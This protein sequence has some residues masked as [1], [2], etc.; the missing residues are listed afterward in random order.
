[1]TIVG[2]A[3]SVYGDRD[4]LWVAARPYLDRDVVTAAS[5]VPG[6]SADPVSLDATII[7]A[8]DFSDPKKPRYVASSTIEGR[9][10]DQ[11]AMDEKAGSLRVVTTGQQV[12]HPAD[13]VPG[14]Q[15]KLTPRALSHLVVL[16]PDL[17]R[18]KVTGSA[19]DVAP[20]EALRTSRFIGDHAF[21]VTGRKVNPLV[22]IDIHDP[23]APSVVG[24]L[25]I[26]GF[27]EF[28]QPMDDTHLLT[29]GRDEKAGGTALSLSIF[30]IKNPNSP[31]VTQH[32]VYGGIDG[33]SA[34]ESDQKAFTYWADRGLLAFPYLGSTAGG[35]GG[36]K[37]TLEVFSVGASTGFKKLGSIDH[38]ALFAS[39]DG[40]CDRSYG[41]DVRRGTFIEDVVFS[42]SY[43]G[44]IA[45]S[46]SD[47]GTPLAKLQLPAPGG[48]SWVCKLARAR[49]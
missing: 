48:P 45:S 32:F 49:G 35:L 11:F 3:D 18:L 19:G 21:L 34:A 42:T 13:L 24:D 30:D 47:P 36:L 8:F 39:P 5:L 29:I 28:V 1:M 16:T 41:V 2:R 22:S 12:I 44:V 38:S 20:G 10:A 26:A 23:T 25:E 27:S 7:H 9:V 15:A 43:G 40:F 17:S 37:S 4:T 6:A 33:Y 31:Q 46:V 14:A